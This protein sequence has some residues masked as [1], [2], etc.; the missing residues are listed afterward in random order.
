MRS[1]FILILALFLTVNLLEAQADKSNYALLWEITASDLEKPSYLFGTMHV[2]DERAAEFPDSL[3][4]ALENVD[5][6]AME[7]HPDSMMQMVMNLIFPNQKTNIKDRLSPSAYERLNEVV[8]KKTGQPLD[9]LDSQNP[10]FI[11]QLLID[12]EEPKYTKKKEQMVD[13]YLFKQAW[14]MDKAT[15]GLEELKDYENVT[16]QFFQMFERDT[17]REGSEEQEIIDQQFETMIQF[18]QSGDIYAMQKWLDTQSIDADYD[19]AMLDTRNEKMTAQMQVLMQQQSV[20][21]AVGTAHLLGEK[22]MLNLLQEAG[23]RVRKV[24]ATFEDYQLKDYSKNQFS[25]WM[26]TQ[27]EQFGYTVETP[28]KLY[29]FDQFLEEESPFLDVKMGMDM[30]DMNAYFLCSIIIPKGQGKKWEKEDSEEMVRNFGD[31]ENRTL[32]AKRNI[33][34]K[35]IKGQE[36]KFKEED[37]DAYSIWRLFVQND[38][39]YLLGVYRQ[40]EALEHPSVQYFFNS[41]ELSPIDSPSNQFINYESEDGAYSVTMPPDVIYKRTEIPQTLETGAKRTVIVHT[42]IATD[43][44]SGNYYLMQHNMLG[45]GIMVEDVQVLLDNTL[46]RIDKKWGDPMQ[47]IQNITYAGMQG[48][49]ASYELPDQVINARVFLRGN[50]IYVLVVGI[51]KQNKPGKEVD[52]FFNSLKLKENLA[53]DLIPQKIAEMDL[54]INMPIV[55]IRNLVEDESNEYPPVHEV[56]Y[57]SM[58]T[59]NG[60]SYVITA[61]QYPLYHEE[62]DLA[63]FMSNY[64]DLLSKNENKLNLIDTTFQGRKA[65]YIELGVPEKAPGI[66][67][68]LIFFNGPDLLELNFYS[69]NRV[70]GPKA[71]DF[72]NSLQLNKTYAADYFVSDRSELLLQNIQSQDSIIQTAAKFGIDRYQMS[73]DNLPS[74]YK[75]L[76]KN[77]P[78]DTLHSA[79]IYDLMFQELLY[80]NNESTLPFLEQLFQ[81]RTGNEDARINILATLANLKSKTAYDLFFKLTKAY[82]NQPFEGYIYDD[83]FAP[84]SDTISMMTDYYKD[85]L[86]LRESDALRYY[87]YD[88][89]LNLL[90]EE[91]LSTELV[92][93]N[94]SLFLKDAKQL[95]QQYNLLNVEDE[96]PKMEQ[97]WHLNALHII[98][99]ELPADPQT[100][101]YLSS[102]LKLPNKRIVLNLIDALLMH[103]QAIPNY[104]FENVAKDPY[105]WS[106]LLKNLAFEGN[107]DKIPN[108]L[109]TQERTIKAYIYKSL[110]DEYDQ[111]TSCDILEKREYNYDGEQLS[112]YLFTFNI[113]GY[114]DTYFGVCS[115]PL[116]PD[117]INVDPKLFDYSGETYTTENKEKIYRSLIESWLSD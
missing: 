110:E 84:M 51:P 34:H 92:A 50:R 91:A 67:H 82:K 111:L 57:A 26:S 33:K 100:D 89:I 1:L 108:H 38:V 2:R 48:R 54:S 47:E 74:I 101:A 5:A 30:L 27:N 29:N 70:N 52:A 16:H 63:Q 55:G 98:L 36:F 75:I 65:W 64:S 109:F 46:S 41:L 77:Y 107:L 88:L 72:F 104:A 56:E 116:T 18:Y 112:L 62:A 102:L 68:N 97:Y 61:Y 60:Y 71:W 69:P 117:E 80:T 6:Y 19:A 45:A 43:R 22:G 81:K 79:S 10:S 28:S 83:V 32:L 86:Y 114:E 4:M 73:T 106:D 93:K 115:Q 23:Y 11:E 99:G 87:S 103:Q 21:C 66:N 3:L 96:F 24:K 13:L 37:D 9:S 39:V 40:Q 76:E 15:Y 113:D 85:I 35:G 20:F 95:V 58:D 8:L 12:F 90:R 25:R 53:M 31:E 59:L 14:L 49:A 94:R 44:E 17:Y 7:V 105:Y 78:F 42:A